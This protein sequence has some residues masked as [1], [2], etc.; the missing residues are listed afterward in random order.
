[1]SQSTKYTPYF[2]HHSCALGPP[3]Y[4]HVV[5]CLVTK[6][7]LG[8]TLGRHT[9]SRPPRRGNGGRCAGLPHG[10]HQYLARHTLPRGGYNIDIPQV[11]TIAIAITKG[12]AHHYLATLYLI[13]IVITKGRARCRRSSSAAGSRSSA[14]TTR[15]GPARPC[16]WR[17]R[18]PL[19]TAALHLAAT[20]IAKAGARTIHR[21]RSLNEGR[22]G[23][24]WRRRCWTSTASS[25][26]S[27]SAGSKGGGGI[28]RTT[29]QPP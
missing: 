2:G 22:R 13:T 7:Q 19:R 28:F 6:K 26:T 10:A 14:R 23:R 4:A 20:A 24:R 3:D 15:C 1:V 5:G 17:W 29:M 16:R 25:S 27:R 12:R 8:F 11:M 21:E 18:R 9:S